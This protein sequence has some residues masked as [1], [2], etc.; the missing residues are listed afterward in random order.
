MAR[1]LL[2]AGWL[3]GCVP[4]ELVALIEI[5]GEH[6]YKNLGQQ[7]RRRDQLKET[8]YQRKYPHVPLYRIR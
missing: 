5:D 6:H 4:G 2:V 8:L 3:A 1:W 7:L